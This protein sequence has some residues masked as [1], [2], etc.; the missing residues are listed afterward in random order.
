MRPAA[1]GRY[2]HQA[3]LEIPA[4]LQWQVLQTLAFAT[5]LAERLFPTFR[6]LMR[7]QLAVQ[8][9]VLLS[10]F[11]RALQESEC[12]GRVRNS[13]STNAGRTRGNQTQS[14]LLGH[15]LRWSGK[16]PKA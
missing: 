6:G 3:L 5:P 15:R 9:G 7:H 1:G 10:I 8:L 12:P 13:R 2:R 14:F 11:V 16:Q 4:S